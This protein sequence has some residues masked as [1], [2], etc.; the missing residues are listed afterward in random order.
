M[1]IQNNSHLPVVL[2]HGY[3]A[4]KATNAPIRGLL[5]GH[6][7]RTYNVSLPG[8]NFQD[9]RKSSRMVSD[10]VDEI[11][12]ATGVEKV[13]MVGVSMGGLIALHYL[14]LHGGAGKVHTCVSLGTPFQGT[15]IA[16]IGRL[17]SGFQA[18][19]A[20]QIAPNS[21]FIRELHTKADPEENLVSISAVGDPM[22]PPKTAY[23]R[24]ATNI[25][26]KYARWPVGH[27]SLV[28]DPRNHRLLLYVLQG[29]PE[30]Y[31]HLTV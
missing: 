8:L 17:I 4:T 25:V 27:Y 14:R 11:I 30:N 28:L 21:A 3:Y 13:L 5:R 19:A 29:R 10:R 15:P 18:E 6:G 31:K 22:V 23:V 9:M 7:Y 26:S 16:P 12:R 2:V 20:R 24:G 1:K